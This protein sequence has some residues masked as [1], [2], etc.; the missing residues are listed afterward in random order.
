[1]DDIIVSDQNASQSIET[2]PSE[3]S[4][5]ITNTP[6]HEDSPPHEPSISSESEDEPLMKKRRYF[7]NTDSEE[8]KSSDEEENVPMQEALG[9]K[10]G[11]K[12]Q[13]FVGND[14]TDDV[15][16]EIKVDGSENN[17]H[18]TDINTNQKPEDDQN[19]AQNGDGNT[20]SDDDLLT[21][22]MALSQQEREQK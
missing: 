18:V 8:E 21:L 22:S 4:Q 11:Q 16:L 6:I 5:I 13:D 14:V 20:S 17:Q 15:N 3:P 2:T 10:E 1:M 7:A 9:Q 19:E 12:R